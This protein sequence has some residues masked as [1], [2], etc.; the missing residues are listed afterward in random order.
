[1]PLPVQATPQGLVH[2]VIKIDGEKAK[3]KWL[4]YLMYCYPR[5]GKTLLWGQGFYTL[6]YVTENGAWKISYM[7]WE[8]RMGLPGTGPAEGLG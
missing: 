7:N 5:T 1:V 6:E 8:E 4:L 2:P 3:D